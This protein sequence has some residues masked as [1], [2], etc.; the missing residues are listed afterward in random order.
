MIIHA[1]AVHLV[2]SLVILGAAE[3]A[4]GEIKLTVRNDFSFE[5]PAEGITGGVPLPKGFAASAGELVLVG[6]GGAPVPVQI[7]V[8]GA[9]GNGTPRWV[10]LDF[11]ADLPA[12]GEAVFTLRRGGVRPAP[13]RPIS[14]RLADGVAEVETGAAQFRIDARRF[15]LFDSVKVGGIELI[16]AGAPGGGVL[17]EDDR[18]A[19]RSADASPAQ[20]EFEETGPLR[21]V[22]CVR[23]DIGPR[24]GST[25]LATYVCRMHFRAGKAEARVFFTLRNPAAHVHPGNIWDLGSGGSLFLDDFS[26]IL[27]I[28]GA[29]EARVSGLSVARDRV[30]VYQDSSGGENWRSVNHIDKDYKVPV[31][32]RGYRV[33]RGDSILAEGNR[34]D[35]W[36]AARGPSGGAAVA[37][38]EF[39]QNFPKWNIADETRL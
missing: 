24:P 14:C 33:L 39:W 12:K 8:T 9:Y 4:A 35:G 10:L 15:R 13:A 26:L 27:P 37:I 17:L 20:A 6:P 7:Q 23:G 38:R 25:P 30:E 29:A 18:G 16:D 31:T 34:V 11:D 5:R 21:A 2:A 36:L 19:V 28:A 1:A 32:F 22:L 3:P